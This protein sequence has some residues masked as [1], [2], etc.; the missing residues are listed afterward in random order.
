MKK[1]KWSQSPI[2]S[3]HPRNLEETWTMRI[4]LFLSIVQTMPIAI[5][6]PW[7]PVH[8]IDVILKVAAQLLP[9]LF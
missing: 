1:Q 5:N 7:L 9:H 2:T 4:M 3:A 8:H 6:T